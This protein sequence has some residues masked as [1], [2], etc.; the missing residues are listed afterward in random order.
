[1]KIRSL[2]AYLSGPLI[3]AAPQITNGLAVVLIGVIASL[4]TPVASAAADDQPAST[5]LSCSQCCT[6][7]GAC[8]VVSALGDLSAMVEKL[9]PEP[10]I[11]NSLVVKIDA[12]TSAVQQGQLTPALNLLQAFD[13]EVAADKKSGKTQPTTSEILIRK[14]TD[15]ASTPLFQ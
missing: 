3:G 11:A 5:E 6:E 1:M 7:D 8:E 10:G 2:W 4:A 14:S 15:I 9:V 13:N 12:A